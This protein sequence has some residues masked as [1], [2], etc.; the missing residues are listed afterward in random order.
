MNR[1]PNLYCFI[2]IFMIIILTLIYNFSF[3]SLNIS[4][5]H[6]FIIQIISHNYLNLF[7]HYYSNFTL[8]IFWIVTTYWLH[9]NFINLIEI[10]YLKCINFSISNVVYVVSRMIYCFFMLINAFC[11]IFAVSFWILKNLFKIIN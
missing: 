9:M 2:P 10:I 4:F 6:H 5:H 11:L 3:Y 7:H 1:Y 8:H